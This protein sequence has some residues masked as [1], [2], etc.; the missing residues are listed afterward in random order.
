MDPMTAIHTLAAYCGQLMP[1]VFLLA[2]WGWL[3]QRNK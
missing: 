1:L 3:R 2:A